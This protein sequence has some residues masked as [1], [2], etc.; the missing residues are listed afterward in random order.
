M[1]ATDVFFV[2]DNSV[3]SWFSLEVFRNDVWV[4]DKW[5]RHVYK[6]FSVKER[7]VVD[8]QRLIRIAF[9][10]HRRR[11]KVVDG[12]LLN[13]I[14]SPG[15]LLSSDHQWNSIYVVG[16]S[17]LRQSSRLIVPSRVVQLQ[18]STVIILYFSATTLWDIK[19]KKF[20]IFRVKDDYVRVTTDRR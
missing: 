16:S 13:L 6:W 4:R 12:H 5:R 8:G 11:F 14:R 10:E 17:D 2:S 1:G 18:H 15:N 9:L 19:I 7:G 3:K 20:F